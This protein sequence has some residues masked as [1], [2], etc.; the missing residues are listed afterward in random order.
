MSLGLFYRGRINSVHGA[1]G[2]GKSW[3]ALLGVVERVRLGERAMVIDW[4]DSPD[5][6]AGRLLALGMEPAG[7]AGIDYRNPATGI[8]S[9]WAR[10]A[11]RAAES[12]EPT[13][14]VLDS[15]GEAMAASGVDGN[16]DAEVAGWMSLV[17]QI[18]RWPSRPAVV[19]IDHVPKD[20]ENRSAGAIG[21]QRKLAAITGAAY[22]S[23]QVQSF[24][25]SKAGKLK[26]TVEKD[27][28]GNRPKGSVAAMLHF[29]PMGDGQLAVSVRQ[30]EAQEAAE[31]GEK[32]RP[33]YLMEQ[34]S[35]WLE[36]YPGSTT[37]AVRQGVKG[38]A[39]AV[40]SALSALVEEGFVDVAPGPRGATM[41]T[42]R[43]PFH[44]G[45]STAPHRA[46]T[47]PRGAVQG[48]MTAP[49]DR[50]PHVVGVQ[51]GAVSQQGQESQ[52]PDDRAPH[53]ELRLGDLI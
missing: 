18:A 13:I 41:H 38:K 50:T 5:G 42:V 30:S 2:D 37:N 20:P 12:L 36:L 40:L 44:D 53:Q 45:I 15:V 29:D 51:R 26:L 24:S 23:Q 22:R 11:L 3:A 33:T 25:Q 14:V 43:T 39:P 9:D 34:V 16:S 46:P 48:L 49:P 4:E 28:L 10:S 27:R 6:I 1:S 32:F 21:S 8:G 47:A 35:R 52:E 19:L 17:K 31:A 7:L